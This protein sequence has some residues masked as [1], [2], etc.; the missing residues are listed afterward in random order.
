MKE[1][2]SKQEIIAAFPV[3]KQLR[4]HL[5]ESAYLD[6]V[7]EA[8]RVDRYRLLRGWKTKSSWPLRE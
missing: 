2:V 1:L 5:T 6:L 8:Q 4:T 7:T 3:M